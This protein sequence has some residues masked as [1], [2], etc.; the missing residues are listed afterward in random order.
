MSR[1]D[2]S[3]ATHT[4]VRISTVCVSSWFVL[5]SAG[6]A[7]ADAVT[8]WNARAGKAAIAACIAPAEDPLHE[9]RMYAMMHVA[10]HDA[11]NAIDRRSRPYA[12]DARADSSVSANAAVAAAARDVL[13]ATIGQLPFPAPCVA[14]GIASAE[15]D[16]AAALALIPNG[17]SKTQGI[18]LG[19]AAAAA[20]IAL[21][22]NDGSDTP[23]Q[24]FAY[25]QGVNPGEYRFT[26]CCN[27]AFAPGWGGVT[28]FVLNH[29]SQF[30][31][32]P[33]Y[34][35]SSKKYAD[36]FNEVKAIGGDDIVTASPRTS[37]QTEIGL[38]WIESSPL[39]WNRLARSVSASQGP[40]LVGE[41]ASVRSP[42]PRAGRRIHRLLGNQVFL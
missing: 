24:D 18:E 26:T 7:A 5:L 20:I 32:S 38:F 13:V 6:D 3:V 30:R 33:P 15:T 39:A 25:P 21:R 27:F 37:E 14:A 35:T 17:T 4:V 42:Q 22:S 36:D 29:G 11:L 28:P 34:K 19:Q 31:A 23:L 12:Y 8:D 2:R 16:Y 1:S 10:I 41:R 40:R 9:S